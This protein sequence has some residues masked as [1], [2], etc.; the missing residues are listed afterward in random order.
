MPPILA[1]PELAKATYEKLEKEVEKGVRESATREK[2]FP[3]PREE[4]KK[5]E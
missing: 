4:A 5:A 2:A 3:R 1:D